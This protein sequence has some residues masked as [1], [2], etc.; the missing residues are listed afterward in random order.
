MNKNKYILEYVFNELK[1]EREELQI[2]QQKAGE[3]LGVSRAYISQVEKYKHPKISLITVLNLCD[4]YKI[5]L[6]EL[7][8]RAENKYSEDK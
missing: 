8:E 4:L 2:S 5:D 3:S 6:H 7:L 1:N